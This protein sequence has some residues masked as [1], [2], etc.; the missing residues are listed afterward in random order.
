MFDYKFSE[1]NRS[2]E[3]NRLSE[4]NKPLEKHINSF[5]K[6]FLS[7]CKSRDLYKI[8]FE[9]EHLVLDKNK[10]P[11]PFLDESQ[12]GKSV[13]NVLKKLKKYYKTCEYS[14][15]HLIGLSRDKIVISLEPGAQ[16]EV[17]IGPC[18]TS[19]E[20]EMLYKEFR[21][22]IDPILSDFGFS[23]VNLGYQPKVRASEI[24]LIPKERYR[25]FD[26]TFVD[27]KA[28]GKYM[29]RATASTQITL[30]YSNEADAMEKFKF[31]FALGPIWALFF[32]N[33]PVFEG[34]ANYNPLVRS[35][36][37][38]KT[39]PIR[40]GLIKEVFSNYSFEKYAC[41]LDTIPLLVT[42]RGDAHS[43]PACQI[44][45]N[46]ELTVAEIE[47]IISNVFFDVRMKNFLEL[48]TVDSLKIGQVMQLINSV[49]GS[50]YNSKKFFQIK[51]FLGDITFDDVKN[52]KK[53]IILKGD[54]AKVYGHSVEEFRELLG[55]ELVLDEGLE[56]GLESGLEAGL[57]K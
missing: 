49:V 2:P 48:R 52:A 41:L 33:T 42:P 15:N 24:S 46:R 1:N 30:D 6:Y 54:Q 22:Q 4:N 18:K 32:A 51:E 47:Y 39:D 35:V 31:L 8:G 19:G 26:K 11:L 38:R 7:G 25:V 44:Y 27:E 16:L 12:G 13:E 36:I 9:L 40:A 45:P 23:L 14:Q 29:M 50:V 57:E 34:K 43:A 17:S 3:N 55:L 37:W 56:E 21:Q 10:N 53:Q 20:I 5:V 28:S